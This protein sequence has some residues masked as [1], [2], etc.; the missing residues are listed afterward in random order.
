MA[1]WVNFNHYISPHK[2]ISAGDYVLIR[3]RDTREAEYGPYKVLQIKR[4]DRDNRPRRYF[5]EVADQPWRKAGEGQIW[6]IWD[7]KVVEENSPRIISWSEEK[8]LGSAAERGSIEW[9]DV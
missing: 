5:V 7:V 8:L 1:R 9:R 4:L 3:D 2:Q 6:D